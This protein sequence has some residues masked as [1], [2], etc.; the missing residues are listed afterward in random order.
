MDR[1]RALG[2]L[3]AALAAAAGCNPYHNLD[4]DFYLGPVDATKFPNSYLGAGFDGA[5]SVGTIAPAPAFVAGG[6]QVI[7]Y[8]F[9]YGSAS[10]S[11]LRLRTEQAGTVVDREPIYVFDGDPT[12]DSKSCSAPANYVWDLQRDFV[13]FD[14]QGNVFQ[15]P[16]G[17]SDAP[18]LP[19][20][21]NYVPIYA[22]VPVTSNGEDC[23]SVH[24]AEFLVT[25]PKLSLATTPPPAGTRRNP[26]GTPDGKYIAAA[27]VDPRAMVLD[28]MGGLDSNGLGPQRWGFYNHY[29]V[30]Y[31]EGGYVP[32]RTTTVA[33]MDGMPDT[34]VTQARAMLMFAPNTACNPAH[35]LDDTAPCFGTGNDVIDGVGSMSGARG[36]AGYSPVCHLLTYTPGANGPATDPS[37]ID[38]STLDPD[39]NS[40]VYCL[41]LAQ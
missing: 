39:T 5:G 10:T 37:Q 4:G 36:Q 21:S 9:P 13:R 1:R 3:A 15:E 24:S 34:T 18:A 35:P 30:A 19:G 12:Q 26:Q 33:G 7:Y 31:L 8:G 27:L 14:R 17:T 40:F 22:E 32:T 6:A 11:A 25:N 28:E 20:A 2:L 16:Q 29:L 23:N 41:Q 38:M